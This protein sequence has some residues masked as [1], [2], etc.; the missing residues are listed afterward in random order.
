MNKIQ[1]IKELLLVASHNSST[2]RI[3]VIPIGN[4]PLFVG[5]DVI[6]VNEKLNKKALQNIL[7]SLSFS[8]FCTFKKKF[9][10]YEVVLLYQDCI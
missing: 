5:D 10:H 7:E 6:E 8:N 4:C 3:L 2:N 9:K 1:A